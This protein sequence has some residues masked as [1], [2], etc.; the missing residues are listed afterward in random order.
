MTK[1]WIRR[2]LT[3]AALLTL[4]AVVRSIVIV[5]Q[6]ESVLITE[7]GRPIRLIEQPG[8]H[9]RWPH[10][11][12][13]SFDRRLQLETPP[14]REML[15]KDKKNLEV[16]WYASWRIAEVGKFLRTVRTVP[17]ASARLED[18]AASVLAAELG[19]HELGGLVTVSDRSELDTMMSALTELIREQAGREH[20]VEVV[21]VRLR[22]LNYPEEVRSAVFEQI[23]SERQRVAAATRAE[24]ESQARMIRSAADR[25]RDAVLAQAEADAARLI[26]EGEA[27]A[28]RIANE[29]HA[30]DPAFYQFLK[31]LETYRKALDTRTTL[32]LSADSRFL[33]LLTQG[34]PDPTAEKMNHPEPSSSDPSSPVAASRA[35]ASP[36][37]TRALRSEST[38]A[39]PDTAAA[40]GSKP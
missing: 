2:M 12:A 15:T 31:T 13:R 11:S 16:A 33:R 4:I 38:A 18:M 24:G 27:R 9:F 17:D 19:R 6:A 10:H 35:D 20:G 1:S 30:A 39:V 22:R 5:D 25:D 29:A 8:L 3:S 36:R 14:A 7:F 21:A 28:A 32:V 40:E 34:V 23:R 26:G 37:R